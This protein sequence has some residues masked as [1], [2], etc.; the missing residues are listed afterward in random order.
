MEDKSFKQQQIE[1]IK[2][3]K[4]INTF[5]S[6]VQNKFQNVILASRVVTSGLVTRSRST[7]E[8]GVGYAKE[9]VG[10]IPV[11]GPVAR[12]TISVGSHTIS[13]TH[14]ARESQRLHRVGNLTTDLSHL[15]EVTEQIARLLALRYRKQIEKLSSQRRKEGFLNDLKVRADFADKYE[16]GGIEILADSAVRR[17]FE[18]IADGQ[19][20]RDGDIVSQLASAV[21]KSAG[22][23]PFKKR[24]VETRIDF[25][26]KQIIS[27]KKEAK[28]ELTQGEK[29]FKEMGW[30]DE[31]IFTRTGIVT[32]DGSL[33]VGENT[34]E[35][36]KKKLQEVTDYMNDSVTWA[37]Q[38]GEAAMK[39]VANSSAAQLRKLANKNGTVSVEV[40]APSS[41]DNHVDD[42]IITVE[43]MP[44]SDIVTDSDVATTTT[45]SD[46]VTNN[47]EVGI[48]DQISSFFTRTAKT[49][50]DTV[51]NTVTQVA[52][53]LSSNSEEERKPITAPASPGGTRVITLSL[54]DLIEK[55]G[56][57][58]GTLQEA[59]EYGLTEV[60]QSEHEK[61]ET[62]LY[63]YVNPP[64]VYDYERETFVGDEKNGDGNVDIRHMSFLIQQMNTEM[65]K[66]KTRIENQDLLIDDLKSRLEKTTRL[67]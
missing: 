41:N 22:V 15:E 59:L 54:C 7:V 57:R 63:Y 61:E 31:G 2:K 25:E 55:Y 48:G 67:Q 60:K 28:E 58:L 46:V 35:S 49:V 33:Y 38:G 6:Q 56:Y 23:M 40:E 12:A 20:D 10:L 11:L 14:G 47:P 5:Y 53:K 62:R 3:S 1:Y 50:S 17:M 66:M 27:K 34:V 45:T 8:T 42:S 64:V 13:N 18:F 37:K 24:V 30:N 39:S 44:S 16:P 52:D 65:L 36:I 21:F 19:I 9:A 26:T 32:P 4:A 43:P 29:D 51:S